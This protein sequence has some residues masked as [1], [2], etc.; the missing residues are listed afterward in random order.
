MRDFVVADDVFWQRTCSE[1]VRAK[2]HKL[3]K[4]LPPAPVAIPEVHYAD[5][6]TVAAVVGDVPTV[7]GMKIMRYEAM[8]SIARNGLIRP[9]ARFNV[10]PNRV[11]AHIGA[12]TVHVGD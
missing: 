12:G 10:N 5:D 7:A 3:G 9:I 8:M 4:P 1:I 6:T 2:Y 11:R